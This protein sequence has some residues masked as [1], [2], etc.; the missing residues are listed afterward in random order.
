MAIPIFSLDLGDHLMDEAPVNNAAACESTPLAKRPRFTSNSLG[1]VDKLMEQRVPVSTKCTT[2]QW[3]SVFEG[4]CA[5]TKLSVNLKIDPPA[6][7]C[8]AL[9]L[10]YVNSRTKAGEAY[11]RPSLTGLRAALH[12]HISSLRPGMNIITEPD[13]WM[14]NE[15]LDAC[16]KEI[17]RSGDSKPARHEAVITDNDM[18]KLAR[19]FSDRPSPVV[20]TEAV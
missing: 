6:K 2:N 5:T 11:Q 16:L 10:C 8:K 4:Y 3:T 19:Y 7:I 9:A 20:L 17:K 14:A 1:D 18:E 13:F 12:S 15:A